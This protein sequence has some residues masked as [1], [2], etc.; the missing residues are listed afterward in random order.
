[1]SDA[2]LIY[3]GDLKVTDGKYTD[4]DGKEKTRYITVGKLYHSPHLSRVSIYMS[5]T[6]TTEGK[7]VNAYPHEGYEKPTDPTTEPDIIAEVTDEPI[8][9]DDIPF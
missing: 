7:W 8:S 9:L 3:Y 5:P 4:R 6:A 2:K 1:M